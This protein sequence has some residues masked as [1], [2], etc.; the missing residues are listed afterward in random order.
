MIKLVLFDCDDT[1]IDTKDNIY[2][3]FKYVFNKYRSDIEFNQSFF[4]KILGPS[5][6]EV[7]P[8]YIDVTKYDLETV[9]EEYRAATLKTFNKDTIH[10][11]SGAIDILKA[12]KERNIKV[13]ICSSR[14]VRSVNVLL[15]MFNIKEYFDL[16]IG[17]DT[18]RRTKPDPD[19]IIYAMDYY[20]LSKDE[21]YMVGDHKNDVLA[22]KSCGVKVIGVGWSTYGKE[23]LIN[24]GCDYI[25]NSYLDIIKLL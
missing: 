10:L 16:V 24:D 6:Y 2:E 14:V 23:R 12:L 20:D 19:P 25:I 17:Y 3:G 21:L 9:C 22:A 4:K 15:D 13:G 8:Q 5:L 11:F 18:C 1:L 7:F